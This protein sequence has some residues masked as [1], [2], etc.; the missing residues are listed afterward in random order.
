MPTRELFETQEVFT[1]DELKDHLSKDGKTGSLKELI[2]YHLGEGNI[3]QV[4]KGLF[5]SV[6]AEFSPDNQPV[7]SFLIASKATDDA[8][9]GYYTALD[10]MGHAHSV[11][12][13][14]YFL[15]LK[16]KNHEKFEFRGNEYV[17]VQVSKKLLDRE[18]VKLGV[19]QYD[20]KGEMID[21]TTLERTL[22]DVLDRPQY[23]GG[24]EQ[25]WR[26]FEGVGYLQIENIIEYVRALDNATTA[27]KVGYFLEDNLDTISVEEKKLV[28]LE[29]MKP[30]QRHY[31]ERDS[32]NGKLV[33]RWNLIVPEYILKRG[34]QE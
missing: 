7:D 26:S 24:W 17:P 10:L 3:G 12:H 11:M 29:K 18:L 2:Q 31:M 15:T 9:L 33:S 23:G 16:A 19:R 28:E 30:K 22:V 21:V 27:A 1:R 32:A 8:V 4:K 5:Y 13:R 6:E 20:R 34:W 14:Y 25:I